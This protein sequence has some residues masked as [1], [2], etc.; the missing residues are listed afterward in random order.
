[1]ID[2]GLELLRP[3]GI[4]NPRVHFDIREDQSD[5]EA[6]ER[7]I[8]E[9]EL[10]DG[11]AIIN[12][13]AGWPSRLWPW[14]DLPPLPRIL[15]GSGICRRWSPGPATGN[16]RWP[17]K[18]RQVP[19]D[20]RRLPPPTRCSNCREIT[21]R[22]RLFIS[23]D[24]G[25]LYLAAAFGTPCVAFRSHLGGT[26]P[27]LRPAAHCN[28]RNARSAPVPGPPHRVTGV[29]GSHRRG[30]CLRSV[31]SDPYDRLKTCPTPPGVSGRKVGIQRRIV[32][33]LEL[34]V[35]FQRWRPARCLSTTRGRGPRRDRRCCSRGSTSR[36]GLGAVVD[37]GVGPV[38]LLFHVIDPQ[39]RIESRSMTLPGVSVF[40]LARGRG[41]APHA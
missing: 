20:M 40:H 31:R 5:A 39:G 21:R 33:H 11:F 29:D 24:T 9:M 30:R 17:S 27:A 38:G 19:A 34:A 3:L 1:M 37:A 41:V 26:N 13:A 16:T 35:D 28:H 22:A 10:Q 7:V 4:N 8:R 12:P 6:A 15:A 2:Q 36:A 23:S 14:N 25:P 18:S 32:V